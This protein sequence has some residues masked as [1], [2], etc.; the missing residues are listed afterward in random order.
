MR[1]VVAAHSQDDT[2][3]DFVKPPKQIKKHTSPKVSKKAGARKKML[4]QRWMFPWPR[5]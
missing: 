2:M 4:V 3:D 5:V 1:K